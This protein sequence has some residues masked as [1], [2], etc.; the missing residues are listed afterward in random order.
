M[1]ALKNP[2][3]P[4][5]AISERDIIPFNLLMTISLWVSELKNEVRGF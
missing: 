3:T 5:I 4:V 2:K 1:V